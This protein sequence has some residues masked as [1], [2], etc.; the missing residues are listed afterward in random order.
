MAPKT[1]SI[2][3]IIGEGS[4]FEGKFY[5]NGSLKVDG[6]FEGEIYTEDEL[7]IGE[8][9]KVRTD[10]KAKRVT[11]AGTVIGDIVADEEVRL[12]SSSKVIGSINAPTVIIEKGVIF[13]GNLNIFSELNKEEDI[14]KYVEEI[15]NTGKDK[16][17]FS[18]NN[19]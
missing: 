8:T 17:F 3:S 7:H 14:E 19:K 18:S 1:N 4:S 6:R 10:I 12:L 11:V 16:D 15:Y 13:K 2:N 9:G 5:I